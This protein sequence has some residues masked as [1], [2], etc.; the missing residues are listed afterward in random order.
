MVTSVDQNDVY[1]ESK[2]IGAKA[3]IKKPFNRFVVLKI[4]ET[5]LN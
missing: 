1:E 4:I 5:F 2:K 3:Y